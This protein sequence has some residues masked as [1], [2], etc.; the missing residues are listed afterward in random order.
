ME[1]YDWERNPSKQAYLAIEYWPTPL[2]ELE[3]DKI[4]LENDEKAQEY[5]AAV[6]DLFNKGNEIYSNC[7]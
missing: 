1:Y 2:K 6:T 4:M 3:Q 5:K 7:R